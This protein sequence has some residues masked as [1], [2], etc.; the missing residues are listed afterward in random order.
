[1]KKLPQDFKE[2]AF[3]HIVYLASLGSRMAG[4]KNEDKA[5]EYVYNQF[6][7]LGID[8][9]K[10]PFEFE[11]Y[12]IS[13]T[14]LQ[15]ENE[16]YHPTLLGFNPYSGV[17]TYQGEITL[18]D[19]QISDKDFNKSIL[20]DAIIVTT[21]PM[22]YFRLIF[23]NPR[24]IIFL[25]PTAYLQLQKQNQTDFTLKIH[26]ELKKF[27]SANVIGRIDPPTG[28][29]QEIIISS[30][31]DAY[32][33]SP[34]ADDN[35]SGV[36]VLI[37]LARFFQTQQSKIKNSLI[38][39]TFG[40]EELSLVGSR[41]YVE[42]H[43]ND[44]KRCDLVVNM[45]TIGGNTIPMIE[46]LGGVEG[47]PKEK[48]RN[49]FPSIFQNR[50]LDGQLNNWKINHHELIP[51]M[52]VSNHPKWL[53]EV[54]DEST[55]ELGLEITPTGNLG[56]DQQA[57]AQAGIVSTGIGVIGNEV[58]G[59]QDIPEKIN[60]DSLKKTGQI[61]ATIVMKTMEQTP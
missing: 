23:R 44:L 4:T 5:I 55:K 25:D 18:L 42:K 29:D 28:T 14:E 10:E 9:E 21:A 11:S 38:F 61:V 35:G 36:G 13:D 41:I 40:A 49:Q 1:L 53:I 48:G 50:A 32:G 27:K 34:G 7:E 52:M 6:K 22:D 59:P 33:D 24:L 51:P 58:H 31:L 16:V 3:S 12:E 30:H 39:V 57:F 8:V 17:T 56:A 15:I 20:Q 43:R 45:D 26:G 19:P 47:I 2:R 46:M 54:I 60:K 37:E